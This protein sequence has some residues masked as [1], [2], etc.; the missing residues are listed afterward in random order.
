MVRELMLEAVEGPRR[1][2]R[3]MRT[4]KRWD[5]VEGSV[6]GGRLTGFDRCE[7]SDQ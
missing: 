1:E 4:V 6:R 7:E 3:A 5:S 2:G